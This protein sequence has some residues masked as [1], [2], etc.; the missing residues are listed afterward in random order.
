MVFQTPMPSTN[1]FNPV[2]DRATS[3]A[4]MGLASTMV[5]SNRVLST[6]AVMNAR[7]TAMKLSLTVFISPIRERR[8]PAMRGEGV[9]EALVMRFTRL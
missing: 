3:F 9:V 5:S 7:E 4:S 8:K 1:T 2:K 6:D